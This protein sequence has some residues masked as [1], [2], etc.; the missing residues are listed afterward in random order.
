MSKGNLCTHVTTKFDFEIDTLYKLKYA[1][2]ENPRN[3]AK[4]NKLKN[5][6]YLYK[7]KKALR[8]VVTPEKKYG[9]AFAW[10]IKELENASGEL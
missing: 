5:E 10:K 9:Y 3:Y 6:L 4:I 2:K 7:R 1:W 8:N